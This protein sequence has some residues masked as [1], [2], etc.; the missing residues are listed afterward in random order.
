MRLLWSVFEIA[1][2]VNFWEYLLLNLHCFSTKMLIVSPSVAYFW[3]NLFSATLSAMSTWVMPQVKQI[4]RHNRHN[5]QTDSWTRG[6]CNIIVWHGRRCIVAKEAGMQQSVATSTDKQAAPWVCVA[7]ESCLH[8]YSIMLHV[9][10]VFVV[11]V[12]CISL[13]LIAEHT[14]GA[15]CATLCGSC[16]FWFSDFDFWLSDLQLL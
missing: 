16:C 12:G 2:A 9:C 4:N 10:V 15:S 11:V 8:F 7:R 6:G 5:G 13:I 14:L 3:W 1:N